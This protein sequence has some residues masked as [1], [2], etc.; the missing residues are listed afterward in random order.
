MCNGMAERLLLREG[1][2][3]MRSERQWSADRL[4]PAVLPVR[5]A[6]LWATQCGTTP[7]FEELRP[8]AGQIEG[9]AGDQRFLWLTAEPMRMSIDTNF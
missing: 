9:E 6:G 5:G 8:S 1:L 2:Y 4:Q 7:C 3:S